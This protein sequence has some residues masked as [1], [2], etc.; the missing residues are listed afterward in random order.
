MGATIN[1]R[2]QMSIDKP[3]IMALQTT[4]AQQALYKSLFISMLH[5]LSTAVFMLSFGFL[6]KVG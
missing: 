1:A 4:F 3:K 5:L 6:T 2:K